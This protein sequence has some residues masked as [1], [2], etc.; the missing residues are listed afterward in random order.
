MTT[1]SAY[2]RALHTT[3]LTS[4]AVAAPLL[5]LLGRNGE[6][7]V[8]RRSPDL[9][10]IL[11]A[12]A[13]A[14][15]APALLVGLDAAVTRFTSPRISS[16]IHIGFVF[17]LWVLIGLPIA[18]RSDL[19][20][21]AKVGV[22]LLAAFAA[23]LVYSRYL[24]AQRLLMVMAIAP[25]LVLG[26]FL[27]LSPASELLGED[28]DGELPS[29]SIDSSVPV[30]LLVLDEMSG[31]TLMNSDG[32]IDGDLF[33]NLSAFTDRS[34][35]FRRATAVGEGT[36][37]AVPAIL[38]GMYPEENSLP[39]Y[40]DHPRNLL[41]LLADSHS[42]NAWENITSLCPEQLCITRRVPASTRVLSLASDVAILYAHILS[43]DELATALPPIDTSWGNFG[44]LTSRLRETQTGQAALD[45]TESAYEAAGPVEQFRS[46]IDSVA[47]DSGP[48]FSYFHVLLPHAPYQYLPNGQQYSNSARILGLEREHW[49]NDE[50]VVM[51]GYQRYLM[52]AAFVDS[53]FG[54]FLERLEDLGIFDESLIIVT[55]DHGVSFMPGDSRRSV[56]PTNAAEMMSIPLV[57][58]APS[59]TRGVVSDRVA[60]SIDIAPSIL[61]LLGA[62]VPPEMDGV[63]LFAEESPETAV[64][65]LMRNE[66]EVITMPVDLPLWDEAISRKE[67]WFGDVGGPQRLFRVG[68]ALD[69]LGTVI[70]R[71]GDLEDYAGRVT[72]SE[73]NSLNLVD[74]SGQSVPS[75]FFGSVTIDN[76][77]S[78]LDLALA[79][80]GVVRATATVVWSETEGGSGQFS[81][82]VP[83]SS[84]S[85]GANEVEIYAISGIPGNRRFAALISNLDYTIR[86]VRSG[87]NRQLLEIVETGDVF[88]EV[89]PGRISGGVDISVTSENEYRISGW[90]ADLKEGLPAEEVLILRGDEVVFRSLVN[91]ERPD[92]REAF[93]QPGI[94]FSGFSFLL[95]DDL[96]LSEEGEARI[97]VVATRDGI[98]SEIFRRANE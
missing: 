2:R 11:L 62:E 37:F 41:S 66:G 74:P 17:T 43:P 73:A 64:R 46:M 4:L 83:P 54:E 1:E 34:T 88:A 84:F 8:A 77:V 82:I 25:I 72:L 68:P 42:L 47:P 92:V 57:I 75:H 89:V 9:D 31:V 95:S 13:L 56:T 71:S 76:P 97:R 63:D 55:S 21:Q 40:A 51:R 44:G 6:F 45:T 90:A 61:G 36:T 86:A 48:Q 85:Q 3:A 59:Q 20:W 30:F 67:T 78:E 18:N 32:T 98:A 79:I 5:D 69:T 27:Y 26:W 29:I 50:T 7:F 52:Q 22:A 38:T 70:P 58:K 39:T 81:T 16:A 60:Q 10:I 96:V 28:T 33:P 14:V 91:V 19:P 23:T 24:W 94:L 15:A 49:V 35:W 87:E 12:L 53:L 80:N 93:A 65:Q